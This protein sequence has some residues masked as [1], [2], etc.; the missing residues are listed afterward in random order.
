MLRFDLMTLYKSVYYY[1][2]Y[3]YYYY[4]YYYYCFLDPG[5]QFP[6]NGKNY[7]MQCNV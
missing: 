6:G 3:Y 5:T 7:A 1:Y 4:H 2:Y